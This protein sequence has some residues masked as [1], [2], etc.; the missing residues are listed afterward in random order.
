MDINVIIKRPITDISE[1]AL[2]NELFEK[3]HI[4]SH[5][6]AIFNENSHGK[7]IS[8]AY[9][10]DENNNPV[11]ILIFEHYSPNSL[12]NKNKAFTSYGV[13]R[14]YGCI[15]YMGLYVKPEYRLKG[16]AKELV[17]SMRENFLNFINEIDID[18]LFIAASS[19]SS[20]ILNRNQNITVTNAPA[21]QAVWLKQAKYL[22]STGL[23][24]AIIRR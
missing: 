6:K 14:T 8:Y 23:K 22:A 5:F 17:L 7:V 21:N 13:K 3:K 4:Q 20:T 2:E 19:T 11:S 12:F 15:G 16:L 10:S 24:D 18:F 1:W 9:H